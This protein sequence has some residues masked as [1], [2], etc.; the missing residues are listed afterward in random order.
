MLIAILDRVVT[1]KGMEEHKT[2]RK[3]IKLVGNLKKNEDLL[4]PVDCIDVDFGAREVLG[5]LKTT[6]K[7]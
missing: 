3:L 6:E 2:V 4:K 5:T 1:K 7:T